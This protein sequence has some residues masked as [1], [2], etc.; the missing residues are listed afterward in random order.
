M[1]PTAL[2][3]SSSGE[4]AK[5]AIYD[6]LVCFVTRNGKHR[7]VV[8]AEPAADGQLHSTPKLASESKPMVCWL[9]KIAKFQLDRYIPSFMR[10]KNRQKTFLPHF[11]VLGFLYVPTSCPFPDNGQI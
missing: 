5:F 1:L 9:I 6:C 4:G 7:P 8:A 10:A 3:R 2:A 11:Q